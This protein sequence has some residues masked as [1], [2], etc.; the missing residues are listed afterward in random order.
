MKD[1]DSNKRTISEVSPS[2]SVNSPEE[3]RVTL[4]LDFS[5]PN[6][7]A[8]M[9]SPSTSPSTDAFDDAPEWAK[10]LDKKMSKQIELLTVIKNR[11]H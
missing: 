8:D 6:N 10:V 3:K 9:G 4:Q 2:N 11:F 5:T 7:M 1:T